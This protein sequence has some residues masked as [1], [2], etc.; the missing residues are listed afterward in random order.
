[1]IL[2][3]TAVSLVSAWIVVD[4]LEALVKSIKKEKAKVESW[5]YYVD[6][7]L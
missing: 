1:M 4:F 2:G 7:G 5:Q 6:K 3:W